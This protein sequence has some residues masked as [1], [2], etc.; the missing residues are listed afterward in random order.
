MIVYSNSCSFGAPQEHHIYP[1]IVAS[2]LN[3]SLIN[4]GQPASCNRR[5]IRSSI[6][7]L[8]NLRKN[9]NGPILA[10]VGL[11]FISRTELW[12]PH[13]L[14][15]AS[16]GDFHPINIKS[17]QGLDWS[18]GINTTQHD[19]HRY[20]DAEVTDYYKHWLIH[21]SKEAE[22]T[23]LLSDV[24]MLESFARSM[25]AK[26]LIFCNCQTMPSLPEVDIN[27]PFIKSLREHATTKPSIIDLWNFSFASFALS[28]GHLPKDQ[29]KFG[30]SGHPNE[31]A[32]LA[33]GK[34]LLEKY[35]SNCC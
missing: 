24:I 14:S 28:Q 27:A 7:S 18:A 29:I 5:I 25:D 13:L 6:R 22:V 9:H 31:S 23:N 35:A 20:A 32:H 10:L 17:A 11:S 8:I 16:D 12:Q 3:G 15:T 30:L 19:V 26:I 1:D 21:F 2:G 34:F 33:F 4:E